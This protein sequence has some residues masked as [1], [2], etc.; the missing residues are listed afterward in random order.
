MPLYRLVCADD[1]TEHWTLP[2][3]QL[4]L[5]AIIE[6]VT[7][8]FWV[9][10]I[11]IRFDFGM[12][13]V[14][15]VECR[16]RPYRSMFSISLYSLILSHIFIY[17][18]VIPLIWIRTTYNVIHIQYCIVEMRFVIL[19]NSCASTNNNNNLT[20]LFATQLF[21][22]RWFFIWGPNTIFCARQSCHV[23]C[24]KT[25]PKPDVMPYACDL[26][27]WND[28]KTSVN[29]IYQWKSI[30]GNLEMKWKNQWFHIVDMNWWWQDW[31]CLVP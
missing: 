14:S 12:C 20:S 5:G 11:T 18:L 25:N 30:F 2:P 7:V 31:W 28:W 19:T 4:W 26:K 15:G 6:Y 21:L 10:S 24:L 27:L 16:P 8:M 17:S 3:I 1:G 22:L 13:R 29:W 23:D 9:D